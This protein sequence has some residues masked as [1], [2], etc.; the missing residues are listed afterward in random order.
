MTQFSLVMHA[1]G[2]GEVTNSFTYLISVVHDNGGA[3]QQVTRWV[4]LA[5]PLCY[6]LAEYEYIAFSIYMQAVQHSNFN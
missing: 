5:G 6:G 3:Y 2:T 4:G 1:M